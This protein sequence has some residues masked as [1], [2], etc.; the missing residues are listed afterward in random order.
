M[1]PAIQKP[2]LTSTNQIDNLLNSV[3]IPQQ[4]V[5]SNISSPATAQLTTTTTNSTTIKNQP[6]LP[7]TWED[8]KGK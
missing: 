1:P 3:Q 6:K 8:F 4:E 7:K 5:S 2:S